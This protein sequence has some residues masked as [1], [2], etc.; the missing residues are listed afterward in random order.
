MLTEQSYGFSLILLDLIMP[1]MDGFTFLEKR[2]EDEAL[3]RIPVI[4]MTSEKSA[5]V[6]SIR[7]GAS[8]FITKPFEMPEVIIARCER[9]V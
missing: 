8:D 9:I 4:V 3:R 6:K 2:K 5:E 1:V 7:L